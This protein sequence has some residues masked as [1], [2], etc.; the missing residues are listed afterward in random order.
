V[1]GIIG[2]VAITPSIAI[3]EGTQ[4]YNYQI[5]KVS[6]TKGIQA[7]GTYINIYNATQDT[8]LPTMAGIITGSQMGTN[9][10]LAGNRTGS[11][12]I[13]QLTQPMPPTPIS[14]LPPPP[15]PTQTQTPPVR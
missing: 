13:N 4:V 6:A 8:V 12:T 1:S 5:K 14:T 9:T 2:K 7:N 11:P 15:M 3:T 10:N